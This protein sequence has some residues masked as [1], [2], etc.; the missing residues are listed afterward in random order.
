MKKL[1][2][3]CLLTLSANLYVFSQYNYLDSSFN[4]DGILTYNIPAKQGYGESRKVAIQQDGKIVSAGSYFYDKFFFISRAATNGN[5]DTTFGQKGFIKIKRDDVPERAQP[6]V[7]DL[8][9]QPDNKILV[10][11][12][13]FDGNYHPVLF[14]LNN[15]GSTDK[16]FGTNG[17]LK[18]TDTLPFAPPRFALQKDGKILLLGRNYD[19]V[20]IR[21]NSNGTPDYSFGDNGRI[22]Q[23]PL[24]SFEYILFDDIAQDSKGRI[25]CSGSGSKS[26]SNN[27]FLAIAYLTNGQ[28]DKSFADN[29]LLLPDFGLGRNS[30]QSAEFLKILQGDKILLGGLNRN[31][32]NSYILLAQYK[33]DGSPDNSFG[34]GGKSMRTFK[35][36]VFLQ[37]S[38]MAVSSNGKITFS[39]TPTFDP[40]FWQFNAD[41]SIDNSFANNGEL[42]FSESP[43]VSTVIISIAFQSDNKLVGVGN[44]SKNNRHFCL[45]IRLKNTDVI[46]KNSIANNLTLSKENKG[47]KVFP[48]PA[49]DYINISGLNEAK[50]STINIID[51]SGKIIHAQQTKNVSMFKIN[52]SDLKSGIYFIQISG[53]DKVSSEKI[54]K[55]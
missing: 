2:F 3:L 53:G 54:I 52:I 44:N 35:D 10:L 30:Y 17:F 31:S 34:D 38:D 5:A 47:L 27:S 22:I 45:T 4:N 43:Y 37:L 36:N 12:D 9:I 21:Y 28:I 51:N 11:G 26:L 14:R 25:I 55:Q 48:N 18:V 1:L 32:N 39:G 8:L 23:K 49:H 19:P 41:G 16:S 24:P 42:I 7:W 6:Y 33:P 29:G 40:A 50:A 20:I 13:I 15:D 46:F